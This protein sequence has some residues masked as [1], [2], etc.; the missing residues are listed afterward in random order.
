MLP[1]LCL[2]TGGCHGRR[3]NPNLRS[4]ANRASTQY[5]Q[6]GG[7]FA[8][9]TVCRHQERDVDHEQREEEAKRQK[10][11]SFTTIKRLTKDEFRDMRCHLNYGIPCTT[12]NPHLYIREQELIM[13]E[14]YGIFTK[15]KVAP[16]V[17]GMAHLENSYF[18]HSMCIYQNLG[19]VPL[20]KIQQ[21]YNIQLIHQF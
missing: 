12:R 5:D 7:T 2:F 8:Q 4:R 16:H 21:D 1:I 10:F 11:A 15:N 13:V 17:M 19:L 3:S 14:K 18:H 20:M 6:G 9:Y